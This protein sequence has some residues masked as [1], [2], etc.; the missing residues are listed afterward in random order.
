MLHVLQSD[1]LRNADVE[2]SHKCVHF[3]LEVDIS[4][5][6]SFTDSKAKKAL[7]LH[8]SCDIFQVV[9]SFFFK[10]GLSVLHSDMRSSSHCTYHKFVRAVQRTAPISCR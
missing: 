9:I 3:E 2:N 7:G 10:F 4:A 5:N 8:E 6:I 1:E